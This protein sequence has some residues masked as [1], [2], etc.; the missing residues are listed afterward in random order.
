MVDGGEL[1]GADARFI[2]K[3][4]QEERSICVVH[5]LRNDPIYTL[6]TARSRQIL[7]SGAELGVL[8]PLLRV[9]APLSCAD[10]V[11]NRE[12]LWGIVVFPITLVR[13]FRTCSDE[14]VADCSDARDSI[15][16]ENR[17][18][19]WKGEFER[20][21][22]RMDV[23]ADYLLASTCFVPRASAP[24]PVA[25]SGKNDAPTLVLR[26]FS[27]PPKRLPGSS[28]VVDRSGIFRFNCWALAVGIDSTNI[29]FPSLRS[30]PM[31]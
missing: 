29:T 1:R 14:R 31:L 17:T 12:A 23:M 7:R 11:D 27:L 28:A 13:T 18:A 25:R 24:W 4:R 22:E 9:R 2:S 26:A 10:R 6:F 16:F 15:V 3:I 20:C 30:P 8:Q 21:N 5:D 19:K